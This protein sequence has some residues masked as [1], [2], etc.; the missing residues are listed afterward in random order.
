MPVKTN[1]HNSNPKTVS[2]KLINGELVVHVPKAT[3]QRDIEHAIDEFADENSSL[4]RD[5]TALDLKG[6]ALVR[7]PRSVFRFPMLRILELSNNNITHVPSSISE[8]RHLRILGL[9]NNSISQLP[10]S[11]HKLDNL[12]V[13]DISGNKITRLSSA[14]RGLEDMGMLF[15]D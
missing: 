9:S 15:R 10:E 7:F 6:H 12:T 14:L 1:T 2:C 8:L 5:V 3:M 13:L 4:I 11:V